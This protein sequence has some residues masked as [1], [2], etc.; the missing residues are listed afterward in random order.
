MAASVLDFSVALSNGS[1]T[2]MRDLLAG[3]AAL[4]VNTASQ[5]GLTPQ[6]AGLQQLQD[7]YGP[8][9]FTVVAF[10]CNQFG[11]QEPGPQAEIET[12]VCTKFKGTF[13]VMK[14]VEVNGDRA[15]PLWVF[16]KAAKP[17]FM[18]FQGIK[19][20]FSCVARARARVCVCVCAA[21]S[22][23]REGRAY[24]TLLA[25]PRPAENS[26]L[27]SRGMWW[28]AM[29][30]PQSPRQL[31]GT[32][33]SCSSRKQAATQPR[34]VFFYF[35]MSTSLFFFGIPNASLLAHHSGVAS[36]PQSISSR[37]LLRVGMLQKN[38]TAN[39]QIHWH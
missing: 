5:C 6:Y 21:C 4:I 38:L 20:N 18:G 35:C 27:T 36:A 11:G 3:R 8:R 34:F 26:S 15:D 25:P 16:M 28:S 23:G 24:L 30:L 17:G 33:K 22:V 37:S 31:L 13:P 12:L 7:A 29:R 9:G 39:S 19:W 2:T 1:S 14:K 10:P 32:L